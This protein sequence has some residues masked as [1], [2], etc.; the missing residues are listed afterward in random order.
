MIIKKTNSLIFI[1]SL[2]FFV[3][4]IVE[5]I[6]LN[7]DTSHFW[8]ISTNYF[9]SINAILPIHCDEG[10]YRQ[11]S[12][13]FDFFFSENNPYQKRP[14]YVVL[15]SFLRELISFLSFGL[16]SKYIEFRVS[17]IILQLTIL[18]LIGFN[19]VKLFNL[20]KLDLENFLI[21]FTI[22]SIP[23]IRWNLLFPSHGNL[24]LLLLI[25]T[26]RKLDNKNYLENDSN[27][28]L[29]IGLGA[30]LH[31]SAIIYGIIF[32]IIKFFIKK[33]FLFKDMLSNL[34]LV[35]IPTIVYELSIYFS[36]Y[37]SF[38]WNREIYG[39]FYWIVDII[40][41]RENFYHDTSCQQLS[42]FM[43]CNLNV[44]KY[45]V[46]YFIIG[47]IFLFILIFLNL[48]VFQDNFF[49]NLILST[50]FIYIFWAFQGLYP[51]FRFVNY[52]LGYFLFLGLI[53]INYKYFKSKFLS[54]IILTY[55]FS[56]L[57]LEPYSVL[58]LKLNYLSYVSIGLFIVF[59]I[60]ALN[61]RVRK[62]ERHV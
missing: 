9:E 61:L 56:I 3:A 57:Y 16:L 48:N 26:L 43:N 25:Y 2:F 27:Y 7:A 20:E 31:R 15:I 1:T 39:Q 28:F 29:I 51:N 44:T 50:I 24:T 23:N 13:S 37:Q 46:Q 62:N 47:I 34:V 19:T 52:S 17:M 11:A 4:Y 45:F 49:K 35:F 54:L 40:F 22:F 58:T 42:T 36:R 33:R 21:L 10:P 60:Y 38:D 6:F 41:G 18:F 5:F 59:L 14:I 32:M 53:F 30:L 55:E 12:E 8:C